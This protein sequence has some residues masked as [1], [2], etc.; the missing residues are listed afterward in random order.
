MEDMAKSKTICENSNMM[1]PGKPSYP[2]V[3]Q[4]LT[5]MENQCMT[6]HYA[7]SCASMQMGHTPW[8]R[9]LEAGNSVSHLGQIMLKIQSLRAR[10]GKGDESVAE[11]GLWNVELK[12]ARSTG[13]SQG[14][15]LTYAVPCS[16]YCE[17]EKGTTALIAHGIAGETV[18][19]AKVG[20]LREGRVRGDKSLWRSGISLGKSTMWI[21]DEEGETKRVGRTARFEI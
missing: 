19:D 15:G 21:S 16:T 20:S 11:Y 18:R 8:R 13:S 3:L 10:F 7:R 4:H 6:A 17:T 5:C 12:K 2:G 14:H 9:C 1:V